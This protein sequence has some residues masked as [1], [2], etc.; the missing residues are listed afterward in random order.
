MNSAIK[1]FNNYLL[2]LLA[3]LVAGGCASAGGKK[4]KEAS[5]LGLFLEANAAEA[6]HTAV[7]P[8]IRA[9]PVLV[10]VDRAPFLNEGHLVEAAVVE[11]LGGFAIQVKF[12]PHGTLVLDGAT[13]ANKGSRI[14]VYSL[15]TEGRWLAAPKIT[16]TIKDGVFTFTPDATREEADRIVRGLNN[17]AAALG[18]KPKSRGEDQR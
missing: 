12:D 7:V 13:T 3:A 5:T 6:G 1:Q 10:A 11:V 4:G 17:M 9:S 14:V 2:G 8:V 18:N 15:F 16:T